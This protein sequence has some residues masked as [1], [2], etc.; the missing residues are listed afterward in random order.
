MMNEE[1][2]ESNGRSNKWDHVQPK[3]EG[4]DKDDSGIHII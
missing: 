4:E 3:T 2:T 1:K